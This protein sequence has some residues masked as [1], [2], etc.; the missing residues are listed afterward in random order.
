MTFVYFISLILF[1][2]KLKN[3]ASIRGTKRKGGSILFQQ[4]CSMLKEN[5]L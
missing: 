4:H 3:F 5:A 1:D 2:I